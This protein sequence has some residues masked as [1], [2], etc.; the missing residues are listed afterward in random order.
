[1]LRDIALIVL[2]IAIMFGAAILSAFSTDPETPRLVEET[3]R[4]YSM[5]AGV[6]SVIALAGLLPLLYKLNKA[7]FSF[8]KGQ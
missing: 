3:F 5:I 7:L 1:M 8:F 6:G 2:G 4:T